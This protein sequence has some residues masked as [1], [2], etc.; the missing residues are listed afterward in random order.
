M[1]KLNFV[2]DREVALI[3]QVNE[4]FL[5]K[6]IKKVTMD[7]MAKELKISKKTLYKYVKNRSELVQK[8]VMFH[9]QRDQRMVEEIQAK[10]LNPILEI[11]ELVNFVVET[12]SKMNSAI[13]YDLE[14]YFPEAGAIVNEYFHGFVFQCIHENLLKGQKDGSY[15]KN[16]N[17]EIIGK[18]FISKMDL[19]YDAELFPTNKFTFVQVYLDFIQ[20]H[21]HGIT[22]EEGTKILKKIDFTNI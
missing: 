19:L 11:R 12:L 6:G 13:H 2:D 18:L 3:E 5:K 20:Y 10:N 7:D 15:R 16:F 21:L 14:R 4:V 1:K 22:S 17:A 8:S 9:V